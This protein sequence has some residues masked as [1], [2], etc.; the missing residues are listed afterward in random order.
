[1]LAYIQSNS[2]PAQDAT[3]SSSV[4]AVTG[5]D[6]ANERQGES[7]WKMQGD[8]SNKVGRNE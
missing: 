6:E 2:P 7:M 4:E 5:E 1:M 3:E 8:E